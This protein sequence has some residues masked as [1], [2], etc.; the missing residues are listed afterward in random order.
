MAA[1]D[2]RNIVLV[3]GGPQNQRA[4]TLVLGAA[5]AFTVVGEERLGAWLHRIFN[6]R[7]PDMLLDRRSFYSLV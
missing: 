6:I 3:I 2:D 5:L 4:K 1:V 7:R